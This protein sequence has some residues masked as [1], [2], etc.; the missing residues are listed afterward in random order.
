MNTNHEIEA[1]E[2]VVDRSTHPSFPVSAA[3]PAPPS[4]WDKISGIFAKKKVDARLRYS[5]LL[6]KAEV[7]GK[8][9]S[10][11]EINDLAAAMEAS[12]I[13][14]ET[15][16]GHRQLIQDH[17][18]WKLQADKLGPARAAIAE[19]TPQAAAI[20]AQINELGVR[21]NIMAAK[22]DE[23][24]SE[25]RQGT[26]AEGRARELESRVAAILSPETM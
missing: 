2:A 14:V 25:I 4:V 26:N 8:P 22:F 6:R 24:N 15:A 11:R 1:V 3:P 9:L 16:E 7:D 17:K 21:R 10:E 18:R 5:Q 20:D 13:T 19:L 23:L 12:G